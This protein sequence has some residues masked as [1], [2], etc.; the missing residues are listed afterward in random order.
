MPTWSGKEK[1]RDAD[2]SLLRPFTNETSRS[3]F[4]SESSAGLSTGSRKGSLAN[5]IESTERIGLVRQEPQS[6][7]DVEEV[8]KK[9]KQGE[10]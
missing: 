2:D 3:R 10:E 7:E 9:R 4:T 5:V 6:I 1:N 8:K